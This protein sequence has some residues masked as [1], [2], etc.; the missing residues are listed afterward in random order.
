MEYYSAIRKDEY[1]PF[2]THSFN[3]FLFNGEQGKNAPS[4]PD[5]IVQ[6]SQANRV[7]YKCY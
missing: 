3:T 1:L 7:S 4:S 2:T 6:C 5:L